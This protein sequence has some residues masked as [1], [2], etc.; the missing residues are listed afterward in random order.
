MSSGGS[1]LGVVVGVVSDSV[2][3]TDSVSGGQVQEKLG[4][5]DEE[6]YSL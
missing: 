6:L 1:V 2:L 4:I 5:S 3:E